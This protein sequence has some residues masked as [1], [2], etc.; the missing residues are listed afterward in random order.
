MWLYDLLLKL[1]EPICNRTAYSPLIVQI[2]ISITQAGL[3]SK[4]IKPQQPI[5]RLLGFHLFKAT[6]FL[7]PPQWCQHYVGTA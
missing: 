1:T 5:I 3:F 4:K 6:L 7:C 2:F